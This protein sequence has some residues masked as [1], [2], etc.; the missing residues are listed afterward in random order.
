MEFR[1][2]KKMSFSPLSI[3]RKHVLGEISARC[4]VA[5]ENIP[6][7]LIGEENE[8]LGHA[9]EA[10]SHYADTLIFHLA[11]DVCK[12]LSAGQYTYEFDLE[13]TGTEG[14][15]ILKTIFLKAPKL[16]KKPVKAVTVS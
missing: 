8:L 2:R 10:P 12:R 13:H 1:H 5:T 11:D 9:A 14:R 3:S 6:V 4:E 7:Y 15:L 16:Y